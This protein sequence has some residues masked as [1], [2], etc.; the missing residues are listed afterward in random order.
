MFQQLHRQIY[1]NKAQIK[2][3]APYSQPYLVFI[4]G[5]EQ[6]NAPTAQKSQILQEKYQPR[7]FSVHVN[8]SGKLDDKNR[9]QF[10]FDVSLESQQTL[11][12]EH[13]EKFERENCSQLDNAVM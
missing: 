13:A 1:K 12:D 7:S 9:V 3:N 10:N 11:T 5:Q 6:Q 2:T 8:Q 4:Q